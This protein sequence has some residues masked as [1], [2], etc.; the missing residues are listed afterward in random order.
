MTQKAPTQFSCPIDGTSSN[1]VKTSSEQETRDSVQQTISI[2]DPQ[3]DL[4]PQPTM[5]T[6][7]LN[8]NCIN[9]E[10]QKEDDYE[11]QSNVTGTAL[12]GLVPVYIDLVDD[13]TPSSAVTSREAGESLN[14]TRTML[15]GGEQ[16]PLVPVYLALVN[17]T[18]SHEP[19][20]SWPCETTSRPLPDVPQG[21]YEPLQSIAEPPNAVMTVSRKSYIIPGILL[22]CGALIVVAVIAVAASIVVQNNSN[23]KT[24]MFRPILLIFWVV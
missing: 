10:T 3:K 15:E 4:E 17:N 16:L 14:A 20:D 6:E 13:D 22:A 11:V 7:K 12:E 23:Y 21:Q 19:I 8:V 9:S 5:A 24:G 2:G 1:N 18:D